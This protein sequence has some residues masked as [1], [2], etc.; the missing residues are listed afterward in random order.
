MTLA[1]VAS[2][3]EEKT[4]KCE[5][6]WVPNP[7]APMASSTTLNS[8]VNAKKILSPL[9]RTTLGISKRK[10]VST[11]RLLPKLTPTMAA[12][13]E[14]SRK[15]NDDNACEVAV[16]QKSNV[17]EATSNASSSDVISN[18]S[19]SVSYDHDLLLVESYKFPAGED[20]SVDLRCDITIETSIKADSLAKPKPQ[21]KVKSSEIQPRLYS[22]KKILKDKRLRDTMS[23]MSAL[24]FDYPAVLSQVPCKL[25]M[26]SPRPSILTARRN[27]QPQRSIQKSE[28]LESIHDRIMLFQTEN[29]N[30]KANNNKLMQQLKSTRNPNSAKLHAMHN[31]IKKIEIENHNLKAKY[32]DLET[33]I[34]QKKKELTENENDRKQSNIPPLLPLANSS[35]T[36]AKRDELNK[37]QNSF[38]D[39]KKK[40]EDKRQLC[41]D[42]LHDSS[43]G[44]S[45]QQGNSQKD[46]KTVISEQLSSLA[47]SFSLSI[48]ASQNNKASSMM[49][50]AQAMV[51]AKKL[52]Q[53][54]QEIQQLKLKNETLQKVN[55]KLTLDLKEQ[56]D[57]QQSVTKLETSSIQQQEQIS[58]LNQQLKQKTNACNSLEEQMVT[59]RTEMVDLKEMHEFELNQLGD[60]YNNMKEETSKLVDKLRNQLEV[61]EAQFYLRGTVNREATHIIDPSSKNLHESPDENLMADLYQARQYL[62]DA[63]DEVDD[64]GEV[65]NKGLDGLSKKE[66][67]ELKAEIAEERKKWQETK[68]DIDWKMS[69]AML[70]AKRGNPSGMSLDVENLSPSRRTSPTR[71]QV[72]F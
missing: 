19:R 70:E 64:T 40:I 4:E 20:S 41:R 63:H 14:R 18:E 56:E 30:L 7:H 55:V 31:K 27:F 49:K 44:D 3:Q 36:T 50:T 71:K 65:D 6:K 5:E 66:Q 15:Q 16:V 51:V 23:A 33:E 12:M 72:A 39:R 26:D 22:P 69:E 61:Y 13:L 10:A 58:S 54:E 24:T 52:N 25:S 8:T 11:S 32:L 45:R 1:S 42:V 37:Q 21:P 9:G 68:E 46:N 2:P 38:I 60:Q 62:Q 43:K 59:L 67:D 47:S 29:Y 17:F 53:A 48:E 35:I 57:D 28:R 34:N